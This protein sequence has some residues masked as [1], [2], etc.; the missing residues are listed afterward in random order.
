MRY[1][2]HAPERR[3]CE[4]TRTKNRVKKLEVVQHLSNAVWLPSLSIIYGFFGT[5]TGFNLI[6]LPNLFLKKYSFDFLTVLD[7]IV[8]MTGDAILLIQTV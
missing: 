4:R 2:F 3:V 6:A 1:T 5:L 8:S 7:N